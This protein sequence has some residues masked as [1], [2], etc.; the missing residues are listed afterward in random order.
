MKKSMIF[1]F[2]VIIGYAST[3][4]HHGTLRIL[5]VSAHSDCGTNDDDS[6]FDLGREDDEEIKMFGRPIR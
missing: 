5:L 3:F 4:L 2:I 6:I 1:L